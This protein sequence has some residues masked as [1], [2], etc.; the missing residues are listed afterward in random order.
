M[1]RAALVSSGFSPCFSE[2]ELR[3]LERRFMKFKLHVSCKMWRSAFSVPIINE[4]RIYMLHMPFIPYYKIQGIREV[5][6]H[7]ITY[8]ITCLHI[9][10][11]T[12]QYNMYFCILY[13]HEFVNKK[14]I[15]VSSIK[16]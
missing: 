10:Y 7:L 13:I 9:T 3:E 1:T 6:F 11:L 8:K 14:M 15:Y 5:M 4:S 2:M 12:Y 16:L